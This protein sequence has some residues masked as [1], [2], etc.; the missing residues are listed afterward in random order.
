MVLRKLEVSKVFAASPRERCL[1][2]KETS[3]LKR[4][5]QSSSPSV[6]G[7]QYIR[8]CTVGYLVRD[9][10]YATVP[11]DTNLTSRIQSAFSSLFRY[12]FGLTLLCKAPKSMP[13]TAIM[14]RRY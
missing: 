14:L 4:Q 12:R 13:T 11:C 8:S 2:P 3:D 7:D 10:V 1:K 9:D 5:I 6:K